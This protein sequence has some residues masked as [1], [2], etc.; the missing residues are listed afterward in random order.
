MP[1]PFE[2]FRLYALD[3]HRLR[4]PKEVADLVPW[5]VYGEDCEALG[6]PGPHRGLVVLGPEAK[7]SRDSTLEQLEER[8]PVMPDDL[9]GTEFSLALRLRL[10]WTVKIGVDARLTLPREAREAGLVPSSPTGTV[11]VAIVM[12]AIQIWGRGDVPV[13]L[14]A[15]AAKRLEP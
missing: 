11:A 14:Q 12:G 13:V 2:G 15:L 4:L 10:S 1:A 5:F 7:R 3:R 9:A 8:S 6:M